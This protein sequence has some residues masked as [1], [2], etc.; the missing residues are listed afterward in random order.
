MGEASPNIEKEYSQSHKY[1]VVPGY[2]CP[3]IPRRSL[4]LLCKLSLFS[5]T[6]ENRA[7]DYA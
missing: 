7:L 3:Q 6:T 2:L 1:A 5:D 4:R